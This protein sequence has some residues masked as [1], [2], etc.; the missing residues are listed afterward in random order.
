MFFY[1]FASIEEILTMIV[2]LE[3][4][5]K[6]LAIDGGF[7][8]LDKADLSTQSH[9]ITLWAYHWEPKWLTWISLNTRWLGTITIYP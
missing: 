5:N 9:S 8:L 2:P 7:M 3:A 6:F 4:V 1:D